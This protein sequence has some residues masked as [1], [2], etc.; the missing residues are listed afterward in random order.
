MGLEFFHINYLLTR[1][2]LHEITPNFYLIYWRQTGN[3][4]QVYFYLE[5][6]NDEDIESIKS[7]IMSLFQLW[8]EDMLEASDLANEYEVEE[9]II[10]G[11]N[12][13]PTSPDVENLHYV[14]AKAYKD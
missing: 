12:Q 11:E 2:C 6:E 5:K 4:I 3:L 1:A 9:V 8:L 13:E 10:I 14:F 7:E